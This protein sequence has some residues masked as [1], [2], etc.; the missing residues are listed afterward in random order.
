MSRYK[1]IIRVVESIV[2]ERKLRKSERESK[3]SGQIEQVND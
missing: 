3:V 2:S 1:D